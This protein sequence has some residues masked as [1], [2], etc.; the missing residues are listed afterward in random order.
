A[1]WRAKLA[2]PNKTAKSYAMD[3]TYLLNDHVDHKLFGVGLVVSLINPDKISVFFQDGLK[4]MKCGL[5]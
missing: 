3:K 5:S 4:T 2:R 1:E